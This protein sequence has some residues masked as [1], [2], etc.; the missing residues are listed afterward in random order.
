MDFIIII[1]L[2]SIFH[3]RADLVSI[4]NPELYFNN[5]D[6]NKNIYIL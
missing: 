5:F 2:I 1:L 4:D 6:K 3:S